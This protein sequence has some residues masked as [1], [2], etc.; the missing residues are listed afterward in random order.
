M[1]KY[2]Q[3]SKNNGNGATGFTLIEMMVSVS[4][5]AV[6][7]SVALGAFLNVNTIQKK[8]ISLRKVNDNLNY[9]VETMMREIRTG[10]SYCATACSSPDSFNFTDVAG[11]AIVYQLN[12]GAIERSDDGGATFFSLTSPEVKVNKLLFILLKSWRSD[13]QPMLTIIVSGSAGERKTKTT[14]NLQVTVSQRALGN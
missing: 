3:K 1:K 11:G 8:A 5:F 9:A 7:V 12:N 6:V 2:I 4:L 13:F 10:T 14:I